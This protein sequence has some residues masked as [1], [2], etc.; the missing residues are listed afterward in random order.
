MTEK[1]SIKN[2]AEAYEIFAKH[3]NQTTSKVYDEIIKYM[4]ILED[5]GMENYMSLTNAII[6]LFAAINAKWI[7]NMEEGKGLDASLIISSLVYTIL[8]N[9]D[10]GEKEIEVIF[11]KLTYERAKKRQHKRVN[12]EVR[13]KNERR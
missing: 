6:N 5:I 10:K 4:S 1:L 7:K 2:E 13:I 12:V 3:C 9:M 8:A 11:D